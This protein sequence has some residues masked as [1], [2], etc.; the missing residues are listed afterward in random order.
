MT[1]TKLTRGRCD[2]RS[3]DA[4]H[5]HDTLDVVDFG[6]YIRVCGIPGEVRRLCEVHAR[7]IK[8]HRLFVAALGGAK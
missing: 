3:A 1:T 8:A 7:G 5:N 4:N 6:R 2:C